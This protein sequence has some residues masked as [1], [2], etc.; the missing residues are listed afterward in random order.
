MEY[1]F[2]L[3]LPNGVEIS[4]PNEKTYKNFTRANL[5]ERMSQLDADP[6]DP[7]HE[8]LKMQQSFIG[9][10]LFGGF[11]GTP[12]PNVNLD[13]WNEFQKQ[14]RTEKPSQE[15][16]S[17]DPSDNPPVDPGMRP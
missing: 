7:M 12:P 4:F 1:P 8:M 6:V 10:G 5:L 11:P 14:R 3:P 13:E 9:G 15:N 16:R 2:T 17:A